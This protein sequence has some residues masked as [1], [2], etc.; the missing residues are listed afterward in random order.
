M[1]RRR[2]TIIYAKLVLGS[3]IFLTFSIIAPVISVVALIYFV[4]TYP[5]YA[6]V[7]RHVDGP[8]EVDTGGLLW[9]Q[10]VR[11]QTWTLLVSQLLLAGVLALKV[12]PIAVGLVLA[13]GVYTAHHTY[14][15]RVRYSGIASG[16]PVQRSAALD[17][18]AVEG[19]IQA[20]D[21]L[22]PYASAGL[23]AP[24]DRAD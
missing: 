20:Y 2:L 23:E 7:L 24:S 5:L 22:Q 16:L 8:P 15:L 1:R 12:S 14:K 4:P 10:A 19:G 21:S 17:A 9:E 13:S 3:G 6:V 18:A 11:Y